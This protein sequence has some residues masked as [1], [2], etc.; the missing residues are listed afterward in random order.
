MKFGIAVE[1]S[2]NICCLKCSFICHM[3]LQTLI[4]L[5]WGD[6]F[7]QAKFIFLLV[8]ILNNFVFVVVIG[9]DRWLIDQFCLWLLHCN[10]FNLKLCF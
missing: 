2:Y 5:F 9:F 10:N 7:C 3:P 4:S 8:A 6:S 1:I